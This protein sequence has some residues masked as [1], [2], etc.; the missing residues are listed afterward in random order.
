LTSTGVLRLA[1]DPF[2]PTTLYAGTAYALFKTT[3]GGGHWSAV[4]TELRGPYVYALAIN[5][6]APTILYLGTCCDGTYGD[7]VLKSTDGGVTWTAVNTGLINRDILAL[8]VDPQRPTTLYAVSS[9]LGVFR[10]T[11]GGDRW[12]ALNTGLT[13]LNVRTVVIDPITPST[14][15][16]GTARGGVFVS[17][18][19]N[20]DVNI[21]PAAS[22]TSLCSDLSCTFDASGSADPDGTIS[23]YHWDF[24]DGSPV[25]GPIV[26]H[27]YTAGGAHIATLTVM[28]NGFATNTHSEI[29]TVIPPA[30]H[31]GDLDGSKDVQKKY[32][33]AF[34][35]ITVHDADH[36]PAV[37]ARVEGV[38]SSGYADFCSVDN[39]GTCTVWALV[40]TSRTSMTFTVQRVSVGAATYDA[41]RN[42][43]VDGETNG[44]SI[45]VTRR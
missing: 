27:T 2:T 5:P 21:P 40:P 17:T 18:E 30:L 39:S 23:I 19:G 1:I 6:Q 29:V 45:T 41:A 4:A 7:G 15:Y 14:V 37:N 3:D 10:S 36:V 42:H 11:D 20:D 28:D 13:V 43:D 25:L 26:S 22:F 31:I 44:T 32:W 34:V 24:G 33:T 16:A 12:S 38:W 8:A 9:S 35:S